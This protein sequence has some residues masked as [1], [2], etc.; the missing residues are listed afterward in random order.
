MT[1]GEFHSD[2]QSGNITIMAVN[3]N[4]IVFWQMHDIMKGRTESKDI[5]KMDK[6]VIKSEFR[7]GNN[8]LLAIFEDEV[9]VYKNS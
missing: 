5:R 8:D 7:K 3:E 2:R 1:N 9:K 6:K 4:L